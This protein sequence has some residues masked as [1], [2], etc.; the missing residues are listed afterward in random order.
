MSLYLIF[1]VALQ[2]E[3]PKDLTSSSADPLSLA[4]LEPARGMQRPLLIDGTV[5][6]TNNQCFDQS[7]KHECKLTPC[8]SPQITGM[9]FCVFFSKLLLCQCQAA[10]EL[11]IITCCRYTHV[12]F[13]TAIFQQVVDFS[14]LVHMHA[15]ATLPLST[16]ISVIYLCLALTKITVA[17]V[18]TAEPC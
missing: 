17:F 18:Y 12:S 8:T 3:E 16:T 14:R 9:Q 7:Y 15:H 11:V 6:N 13:S 10:Y 1:I 2:V 4:A 5:E